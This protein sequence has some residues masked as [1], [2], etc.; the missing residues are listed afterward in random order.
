MSG[1]ITTLPTGCTWQGDPDGRD[2]TH[3]TECPACKETWPQ[4]ARQ[5]RQW[6]G[7]AKPWDNPAYIGS[8]VGYKDK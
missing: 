7:E 2:I 6:R 1:N 3:L 4:I 5:M 8:N